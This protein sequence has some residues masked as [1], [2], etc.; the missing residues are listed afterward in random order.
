MKNIY[1]I[2]T[3]APA[4]LFFLGFIVSVV[5]LF[6]GHEHSQHH[7]G[8]YALEMPAMWFIMTIAHVTPWLLWL[9]QRNFTRN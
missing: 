8:L 1:S 6:T 2:L 7:F 3:L 5:S 4:P 9:K